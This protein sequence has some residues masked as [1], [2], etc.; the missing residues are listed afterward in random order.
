M[1][2]ETQFKLCSMI[3]FL[4]VINIYPRVYTISI[5][6]P[7][8]IY[9]VF[10]KNGLSPSVLSSS[11]TCGSY[12]SGS[13]SRSCSSLISLTGSVPLTLVLDLDLVLLPTSS[14]FGVLSS[15]PLII[16]THTPWSIFNY[17]IKVVLLRYAS[18]LTC[19]DENR[20]TNT[21]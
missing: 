2:K 4:N 16:K 15:P 3:I 20:V 9:T 14:V 11:Y 19:D 21:Y 1:T 18:N 7:P 13:R 10:V 6:I 8:H 12:W 17:R 5:W